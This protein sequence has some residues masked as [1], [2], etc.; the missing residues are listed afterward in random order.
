MMMS[1]GVIAYK[2]KCKLSFALR[3]GRWT[4]LDLNHDHQRDK[5]LDAVL[6]RPYKM[7][8]TNEIS[9]YGKGTFN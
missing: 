4:V 3:R 8:K 5:R 2:E 7:M 1:C 9:A 6:L